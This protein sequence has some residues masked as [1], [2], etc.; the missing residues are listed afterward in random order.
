M[1]LALLPLLIVAA[2][3]AQIYIDPRPL[4]SSSRP[5]SV[6]P[7]DVNSILSHH[8]DISS[9]EYAP[10]PAYIDALGLESS[11]SPFDKAPGSLIIMV[12]GQNG[13]GKPFVTP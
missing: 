8:L 13:L 11:T 9:Y 4:S 12:E 1:S 10:L 6:S 5:L 2:P 7:P 3:P